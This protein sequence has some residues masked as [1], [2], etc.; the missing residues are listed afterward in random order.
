MNIPQADTTAFVGGGNHE[1]RFDF[2][3][4]YVIALVLI[5]TLT[6]IGAAIFGAPQSREISLQD[7]AIAAPTDFILTASDELAGSGTHDSHGPPYNLLSQGE[8]LG[9]INLQKLGGLHIPLDPANQFVIEP[10]QFSQKEG[11][12]AAIGKL[13]DL[14]TS[15]QVETVKG[16][17]DDQKAAVAAALLQWRA[18]NSIQHTSWAQNYSTVLEEAGIREKVGVNPA[19]GPVRTLTDALLFLA[20]AGSLDGILTTEYSPHSSDFTGPSLFLGDGK[21]IAEQ[22]KAAFEDG[23]RM[24]VDSGT[25]SYP[26]QFWLTPYAFWYSIK[27]FSSS[28][29]ADIDVFAILLIIGLSTIFLPKIPLLNRIPRA[30]PFHR[31]QRRRKN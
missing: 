3:K 14:S 1:R 22:A 18:A 28:K 29:N 5:T 26:G 25:N 17:V 15:A 16:F 13:R 23:N 20:Q 19:Y 31:I 12:Y 24:A 8:S 2:F 7:W 11:V 21:Y 4:G 6:L 27:P 10:L 30:L 9:P